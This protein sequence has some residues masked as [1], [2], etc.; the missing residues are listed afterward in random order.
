MSTY[1]EFL[2]DR[3]KTLIKVKTQYQITKCSFQRQDS[4]T[5]IMFTLPKI[6]RDL[7]NSCA[8]SLDKIK[9]EVSD[10]LS[11]AKELIFGTFDQNV[12]TNDEFTTNVDNINWNIP[13]VLTETA[14]KKEHVHILI[15]FSHM[16]EIFS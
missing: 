7:E 14:G 8:E 16:Q 5:N 2:S 1:S 13:K 12:A 3:L 11:D 9:V 4:Q 15:G 10:N 6:E